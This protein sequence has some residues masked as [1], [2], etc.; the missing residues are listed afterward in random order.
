MI[1]A[2]ARRWQGPVLTNRDS[3]RDVRAMMAHVGVD[4]DLVAA[5]AP[6]AARYAERACAS[7]RTVA[8]C[9]AWMDNGRTGDEPG[10]FC[11]NFSTFRALARLRQP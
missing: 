5:M 10:L 7:C 6:Q 11:S 1:D 4:P 9:H 3:A 2:G 8:R